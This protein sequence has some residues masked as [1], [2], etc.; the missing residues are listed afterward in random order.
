MTDV[1]LRY[2]MVIQNPVEMPQL[3]L[4][5]ILNRVLSKHLIP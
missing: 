5:S 4:V 3:V 1:P 2:A